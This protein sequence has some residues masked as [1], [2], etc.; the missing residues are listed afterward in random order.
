M[1]ERIADQHELASHSSLAK[2]FLCPTRLRERHPFS[3]QWLDLPVMEQLEQRP[4][5]FTEPRRLPPL[6]ILDAVGED[7]PSARRKEGAERVPRR[8]DYAAQAVTQPPCQFA[9]LQ[10]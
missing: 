7:P 3:D 8:P 2:Q 10:E 6:E 1:V 9:L 5:V 4:Q